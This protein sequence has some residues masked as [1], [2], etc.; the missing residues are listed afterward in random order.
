MKPNATA[1]ANYE[2]WLKFLHEYASKQTHN[3]K[4]FFY[5]YWNHEYE[6]RPRDVSALQVRF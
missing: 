1:K 3:R 2:R 6:N 5:L 4:A